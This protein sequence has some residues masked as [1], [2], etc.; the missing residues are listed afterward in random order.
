MIFLNNKGYGVIGFTVVALLIVLGLSLIK[1]PSEQSRPEQ[2]EKTYINTTYGFSF[3]YPGTYNLTE[4]EFNSNMEIILVD[5]KELEVVDRLEGPVSLSISVY[6][7]IPGVSLTDWLQKDESNFKLATGPQSSISIA[8][9][10]GVKYEW[11]GLYRGRTVVFSYGD[12][13]IAFTGTYLEKTDEIY[14]DFDSIVRS[15]TLGQKMITT[16]ALLEYLKSNISRLSQEK[17]VLG[18]T[19]YIVDLNLIDNEHARVSYED[20]HNAYTAEIL[21]YIDENRGIVV[22][23]FTIIK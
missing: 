2:L 15:F 8:G 3:S 13:I 21:F 1:S 22:K 16:A 7:N 18:G 23:E 20:G 14:S 10:G 5:K 17:E 9:Q 6:K 11:D 19:F 4:K 12:V